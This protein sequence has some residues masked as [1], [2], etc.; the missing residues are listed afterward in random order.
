MTERTGFERS[1][2]RDRD[3][4]NERISSSDEKREAV[5]P[6]KGIFGNRQRELLVLVCCGEDR[7]L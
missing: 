2:D 3:N 6:R 1:I 4:G 7:G 5:K